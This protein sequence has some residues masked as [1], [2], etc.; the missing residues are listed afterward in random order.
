MILVDTPERR[1]LHRSLSP[2]P[3]YPDFVNAAIAAGQQCV[4]GWTGLIPAIAVLL[5]LAGVRP[6]LAEYR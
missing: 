3:V 1:R 6:R 5:I 2:A 4:R